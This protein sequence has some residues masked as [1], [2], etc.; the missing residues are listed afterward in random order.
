[1]SVGRAGSIPLPGRQRGFSSRSS[2]KKQDFQFSVVTKLCLVKFWHKNT[3]LGWGEIF[4]FAFLNVTMCSCSQSHRWEIHSVLCF[5]RHK[6]WWKLLW[7]VVLYLRVRRWYHPA[8]HLPTMRTNSYIKCALTLIFTK[9]ICMILGWEKFRQGRHV[10]KAW[11]EV[12]I[13]VWRPKLTDSWSKQEQA[14]LLITRTPR[15]SQKCKNMLFSPT[16]S[17]YH[18]GNE[19][20]SGA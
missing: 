12:S 19:S 14:W 10:S 3:W 11:T 4:Y 17:D 9:T 20:R 5:S 18:D 6:H 15:Q 2:Q 1:M 8:L 16:T 13:C 7:G